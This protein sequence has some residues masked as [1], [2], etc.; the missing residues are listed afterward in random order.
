MTKKQ[1]N[2]GKMGGIGQAG[3]NP[4][5]PEAMLGIVGDALQHPICH[6]PTEKGP[7]NINEKKVS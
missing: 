4:G 1:D 5:L 2:R 3:L 6:K 7:W